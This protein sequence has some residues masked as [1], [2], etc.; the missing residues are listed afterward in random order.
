MIN[1][2][3]KA[4]SIYYFIFPGFRSLLK[5]ECKFINSVLDLGCGR[6]SPIQHTRIP[7]RVG[8]DAFEPYIEESREKNIHQEYIKAD[9]KTVEIPKKSFDLIFCSEVIEHLSKEDGLQLLKIM[10]KWAKKK[11]ILTTPNGF[12]HQTSYDNNDLQEHLSGWTVKD[13]EDLG[14]KVYG[15]NGLKKMSGENGKI[16]IRPWFLGKIII[17]ISNRY[18]LNRPEKAF[19]LFVVK[20][21]Y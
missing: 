12:I 13:F 16:L 18:I 7:Y 20:N 14:F 21:I 17:D 10:E 19:Q 11:I 2:R 4:L 9:L 8:V 3:K 1:I 6:N 5:K 15:I